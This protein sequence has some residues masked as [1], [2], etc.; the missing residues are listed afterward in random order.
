[1]LK[2]VHGCVIN[3]RTS[4]PTLSATAPHQSSFHIHLLNPN[5]HAL[6]AQAIERESSY[7]FRSHER[8]EVDSEH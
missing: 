2:L 3:Q 7:F 4:A 8:H 6:Q 1:M 5:V